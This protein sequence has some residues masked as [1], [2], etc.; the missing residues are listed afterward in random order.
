MNSLTFEVTNKD[1]HSKMTVARKIRAEVVKVSMDK[2]KVMK[3]NMTA[4]I[5]NESAVYATNLKEMKE[6][7]KLKIAC[8]RKINSKNV[9]QVKRKCDSILAKVKDMNC[10]TIKYYMSKVKKKK[11]KIKITLEV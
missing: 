9:E 8:E 5:D 1:C 6:D 11:S 10:E 7:L 4:V 2:V 3:Y